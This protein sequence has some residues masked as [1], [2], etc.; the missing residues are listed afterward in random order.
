[1]FRWRLALALTL[2]VLVAVPL[3]VPVAK[4]LADPAAWESWNEAGRLLALLRNTL[5]LVAGTLALALPAGVAAAVLLYRTDLPGRRVLRFLTVLTLFVPLPLFTSGWQAVLGSGGWLPLALWN[6]PRAT[7]P[8][9]S[10]SGTSWT[11][12]GQGIGSAVWIHAVAGLPWVI[13]LVGQGLRWVERELEEDALTA[14]GPWRVLFH[15]TLPRSAAAVAAV[16]LWVA[17][18]AGT[19]ITVTDV[20]QVR[21]FA[22]EVYTQFVGPEAFGGRGDVVARAVAVNLPFVFLT[23]LLVVVMARRWERNLPPRAALAAPPL[24]F[25]LGPLRWPMGLAITAAFALLLAV[26]LGSLVWRAGLHGAPPAWSMDTTLRH[27]VIVARADDTAL[28]DSLALAAAG[29]VACAGLGLVTCWAALGTR[30]FRGGVL[31]LMAVAWAMPGPL[32]GLGL[33]W[34]I[35][36][37]LDLTRSRL[38]EQLLW[39]GPSLVPA[40]WVD[41]IRFFPCAVAVLWPVMRLL[42]PDLRDAARV[43]GA[44]PG[45]ELRFVV[46]PLSAAACLRAGLA[47]AVL[48]LGELS[49]SKLVLLPGKPTFASEVFTQMHYGVTNDLAARCLLLLGAVLVGG[50]LVA[51]AGRLRP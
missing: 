25:R 12:W 37:L 8:A 22:E 39:Y 5:L 44:R 11:P 33:L 36:R 27:L 42:P 19:E 3:A 15:V 41:L 13:L 35:D 31:A 29:G 40:F 45:Q 34:T 32:V 21:T 4:L 7:G 17:L 2:A 26:P 47:V 9:F 24:T 43:D 46:W 51:A 14:A 23:A 38:L 28:R 1:M 10:S 18:Q 16:A 48:S 20:M 6:V 49:A 50:A 30:W